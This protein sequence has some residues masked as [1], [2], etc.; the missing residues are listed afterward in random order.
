MIFTDDY[1]NF[2][3]GEGHPMSPDRLKSF[4][5]LLNSLYKHENYPFKMFEPEI[6]DEK[7]LLTVHK[8]E[9]IDALKKA[10]QTLEENI[11]FGLGFGDCPI[12]PDVEKISRT[13]V[14][15]TLK[16]TNLVLDTSK[17]YK[18]AFNVLGGL[19]HAWPEKAS[20]F[21]Y[22]NDCNI[23]INSALERGLKILYID[24]D[25]H[26]GD[27]VSKY[28]YK[29]NEVL[30]FS[31]HETGLYLF[32]GTDFEHEVGEGAG[33]GFCMNLPLIPGTSDQEY[34]P[35]VL[36][37]ISKAF[38]IQKPD[39]V[40]WQCGVDTYILDPLTHIRLSTRAYC[41]IAK[42]IRMEIN[43]NNIPIV[44][45]GGGGY[46]PIATARGWLTQFLT[47][48]GIDPLPKPSEDWISYCK[49]LSQEFPFCNTLIDDFQFY[50][51]ETS[52]KILEYNNNISKRL[53]ENISLSS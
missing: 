15:G 25:C 29:K 18:V 51:K 8:A 35:V 20:G 23:A 39:M 4:K 37:L 21:C 2:D 1:L 16:A 48:L 30:T 10:E 50:D 36:P 14:G 3:L 44:M 33:K 9:Y 49:Q 32:P 42:R 46:S 13:I 6:A 34:L 17:N 47:L 31:V 11:N 28:Y 26:S 40:F 43:K 45:M 24:T 41:E 7:K 22:Y 52:N 19:H 5:I 27:G 53:M 38:E 12:F